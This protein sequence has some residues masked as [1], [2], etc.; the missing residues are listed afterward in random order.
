MAIPRPRE[1]KISLALQKLRMDVLWPS[2]R[3]V[4]KRP[5]LALWTGRLRPTSNSPEYLIRIVWNQGRT[6]KV[7][8][9]SPQ[10]V[11]YA[12]HVYDDGSLCLWYPPDGS[13]QE[14][15]FAADTIV[16]WTALWLYYYEA[17][18]QDG[19]WWGEEAPHASGQP[20]RGSRKR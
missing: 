13:F 5:S 20:K 4:S 19:V 1:R 16:P 17:W 11:E 15:S 9:D 3:C 2:F 10:L 18:L 14:S 6:P 12:E 8:V 7:F